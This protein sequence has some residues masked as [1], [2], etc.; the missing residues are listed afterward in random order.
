MVDKVKVAVAGQMG[1]IVRAPGDQVIH[2]DDIVTLAKQPITQVA[3]QKAG[4][5]GDQ[6]A[7]SHYSF[8]RLFLQTI[9][10]RQIYGRHTGLKPGSFQTY[11]RLPSFYTIKRPAVMFGKS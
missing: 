2:G 4:R 5:S 7:H 11:Q 10:P 1:N 9:V 8:C 6:N 3:T